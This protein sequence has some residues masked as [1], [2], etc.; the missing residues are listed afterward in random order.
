MLKLIYIFCLGAGLL[1]CSSATILVHPTTIDVVHETAE[2]TKIDSL[3]GPYM[4]S[5]NSEMSEIIATAE[6]DFLIQ[7]KPSGNLCNWVADAILA[8]QTENVRLS[9]PV[10]CLL[11]TGGIRSIISKGNVTIGDIYKVMPFDNEIVWV[12][13]PI[14]SISAI[15]EYLVQKGGEPISNA[16][17]NGK[18]LQMNGLLERN[19]HFLVITSDYL[20]NGGDNMRFFEQ[21]E[22]VTFTN[23]LM[24]DALIEEVRKQGVLVSDSMN[25]MQF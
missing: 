13:M 4:D 11:N 1:A 24:R 8:N 16:I 22:S 5:V 9:E 6:V 7:R 14:E 2:I 15:E 10:F 17:M 18:S 21:K 23:K 20:F 12:R 19:T 3:I 25:R